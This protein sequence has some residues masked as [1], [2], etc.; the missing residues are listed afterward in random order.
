MLRRDKVRPF[1]ELMAHGLTMVVLWPR[2]GL[3]AAAAGVAVAVPWRRVASRTRGVAGR[4][5]VLAVL[6][7]AAAAA[8]LGGLRVWAGAQ[9]GTAHHFYKAAGVAGPWRGGASCR[10]GGGARMSCC[11]CREGKGLWGQPS[12]TVGRGGA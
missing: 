6:H 4:A 12:Q 7:C 2:P 1:L 9:P 11:Y 5:G 8:R 3:G 10:P